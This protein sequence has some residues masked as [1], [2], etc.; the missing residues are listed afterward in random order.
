MTGRRGRGKGNGLKVAKGAVSKVVGGDRNVVGEALE[1]NENVRMVEARHDKG[2]SS[3][4]SV[5][6][7]V[8][9]D[10]DQGIACDSCH[11]WYHLV[12]Q[13][14]PEILY[15]HMGDIPGMRWFCRNCDGR[16][17]E[18]EAGYKELEKEQ[19]VVKTGMVKLAEEQGN[20]RMWMEGMQKTMS[21]LKREIGKDG[22][23]EEL[24]GEVSRLKGEWKS[25]VERLEK[26]VENSVINSN[27]SIGKGREGGVLSMRDVEEQIQRHERKDNLMV[28][29]IREGEDE[30]GIIRRIGGVLGCD[31]GEG[32]IISLQRVGRRV[33]NKVRPVR[34]VFKNVGLRA[35]L[36]KKKLD[37]RDS[38]LKE[39]YISPDLTPRQQIR[40]KTLRDK[41]KELRSG[42]RTGYKINNERI[43]RMERGQEIVVF[44]LDI[45]ESK[46]EQGQEITASPVRR[47]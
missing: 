36:L 9:L 23:V 39:I 44:A 5:C 6:V 46:N 37:L 19:K 47:Q 10:G 40:D 43:I 8:V 29:G 34:A 22:G 33:E 45:E 14:I 1:G 3:T 42:G 7:K 38:A 15:E 28:M 12:C 17:A 30:I 35:E 25:G 26:R 18:L 21:E 13:G 27:L 31:V 41:L 20:F 16:V 4:C 2:G 11:D 32:D 24:K